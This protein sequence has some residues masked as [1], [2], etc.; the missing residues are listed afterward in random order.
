MTIS[1]FRSAS[2][3]AFALAAMA[4]SAQ[5]GFYGGDIDG[6]SVLV[7]QRTFGYTTMVFDDFTLGQATHVQSVFGNFLINGTISGL[8]YEIRTGVSAGNGGTLVSSG[9]LTATIV[10]ASPDAFGLNLVTISGS[11]TGLDL[12]AGTYYLGLSAVV[13]NSGLAYLAT[14]SGANGTGGPLNNGNSFY[15]TTYG[16][17]FAPAIDYTGGADD[18]SVGVRGVAAVPAPVAGFSFALGFLRRRRKG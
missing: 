3:V 17:D 11:P 12:A 14:T 15:T 16:D 10:D 9:L 6:A 1:M 4:A 2:L 8:L 13:G 5:T 7:A 18:F